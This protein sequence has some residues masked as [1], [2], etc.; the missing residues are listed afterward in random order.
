MTEP[1]EPASDPVADAH[2]VAAAEFAQLLSKLPLPY[3]HTRYTPWRDL[4]AEERTVAKSLGYDRESWNN[5]ELN[6]IEGS[7]F[8]E[9]TPE[10]RAW[11]GALDLG[12]DA[13]D[14]YV[15]HFISLS[16]DGLIAAGKATHYT[17]LGWGQASWD[18]GGDVPETEDM[19]WDEL[20]PEQQEAAYALC[21]FKDAWNWVSLDQW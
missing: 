12:V 9:L 6:E 2:A 1:T 15:N 20:S 13:W 19:H 7:S 17:A 14:C 10:E 18:E 8:G 21:Y 4:A 5:L 16:W 11:A 3:P